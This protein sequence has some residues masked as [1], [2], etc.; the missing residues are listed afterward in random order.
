MRYA[1]RFLMAQAKESLIYFKERLIYELAI[2]LG[3]NLDTLDSLDSIDIPD[4]E[5]PLYNMYLALSVNLSILN[6]M[7][8]A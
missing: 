5:D 7:K 6:A 8:E 4:F 1:G 2:S 3:L